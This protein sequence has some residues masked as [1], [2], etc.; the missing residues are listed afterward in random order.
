MFTI[1]WLWSA[2]DI[3]WKGVICVGRGVAKL[4]E[5]TVN[6]QSICWRTKWHLLCILGLHHIA[7]VL[8]DGLLGSKQMVAV[9]IQDIYQPWSWITAR[10]IRVG[11]L[12]GQPDFLYKVLRQRL[13]DAVADFFFSL[14]GGKPSSH[15]S[16]LLP[17]GRVSDRV[18]SAWERPPPLPGTYF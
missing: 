8:G 16:C 5:T 10:N 13:A 9:Q 14:A 15:F 4:A 2:L 11:I 18:I 1:S 7:S 3:A 17:P 6:V 12:G